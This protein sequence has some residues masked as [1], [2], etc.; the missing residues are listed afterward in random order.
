M[1]KTYEEAFAIAVERSRQSHSDIGIENLSGPLGPNFNVF[2][3][4]NPGNRFG[5]DL[6]CQVVPADSPHSTNTLAVL[7]VCACHGYTRPATG[8]VC[9]GCLKKEEV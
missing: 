1:A 6:R 4:P 7:C 8:V 9:P 3:L 2:A 5:R